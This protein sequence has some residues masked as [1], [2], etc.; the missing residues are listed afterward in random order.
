VTKKELAELRR[1]HEAERLRKALEEW[2]ALA[3]HQGLSTESHRKRTREA[4]EGNR[5]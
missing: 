2:L 5:G 3:D 1:L 4:L